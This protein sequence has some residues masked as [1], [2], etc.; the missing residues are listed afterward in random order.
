MLYG[1]ARCWTP[2][3]GSWWSPFVITALT[4]IFGVK[5]G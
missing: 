1:Y 2:E 3:G 4:L 5:F